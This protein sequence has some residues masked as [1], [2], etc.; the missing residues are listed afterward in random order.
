MLKQGSINLNPAFFIGYLYK[1]FLKKIIIPPINVLKLI[2][3]Q[4]T[5]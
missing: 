2:N 1:C 3:D 4:M 5:V